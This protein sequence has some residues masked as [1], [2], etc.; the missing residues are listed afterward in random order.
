MRESSQETND[1]FS[2]SALDRV[3]RAGPISTVETV[4]GKWT[5]DYLRHRFLAGSDFVPPYPPGRHICQSLETVLVVTPAGE[6]CCRPLV[7]GGW[8]V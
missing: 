2:F 5:D 1:S 7:G 8:G 4:M 6:G 3:Q